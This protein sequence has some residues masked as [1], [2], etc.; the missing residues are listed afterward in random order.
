LKRRGTTFVAGKPVFSAS[1]SGRC[2]SA[3]EGPSGDSTCVNGHCDD[4]AED[5]VADGDTVVVLGR[6][7]AVAADDY[8]AATGLAVFFRFRAGLGAV[9]VHLSSSMV[10][11]DHFGGSLLSSRAVI[12]PFGPAHPLHGFLSLGGHLTMPSGAF[13]ADNLFE[14]VFD[15]VGCLVRS[16]ESMQRL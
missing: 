16:V 12:V 4:C 14:I 7:F 6:C 5:G 13:A 8:H 15:G 1:T 11:G 9:A 3:F 2:Q 10:R